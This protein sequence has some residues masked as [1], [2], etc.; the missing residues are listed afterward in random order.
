MCFGKMRVSGTFLFELWEEAL[1]LYIDSC[2]LLYSMFIIL[3]PFYAPF[4]AHTKNLCMRR[5]RWTFLV[6]S[7]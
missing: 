1:Y 5:A 3:C 6:L 7:K 4:H 2:I